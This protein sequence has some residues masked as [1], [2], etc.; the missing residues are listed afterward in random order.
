MDDLNDVR[1]KLHFMSVKTA[2]YSYSF[3]ASSYDLHQNAY[4]VSWTRI[5]HRFWSIPNGLNCRGQT[6]HFPF[7]TVYRIALSF[8]DRLRPHCTSRCALTP[9]WIKEN[10]RSMSKAKVKWAKNPIF[11]TMYRVTFSI[12]DRLRPNHTSR[13]ASTPAS[14]KI[15]KTQGQCQGQSSRSNGPKTLFF[16]RCTA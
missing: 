12:T 8:T 11:Q 1:P 16:R 10:S 7:S 15:K 9:T 3:S 6:K 4:W 13:C 14:I 5:W 2:S